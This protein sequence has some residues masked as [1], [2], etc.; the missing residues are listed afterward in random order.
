MKRDNKQQTLIETWDACQNSKYHIHL[1]FLPTS[2]P[3]PYLPLGDGLLQQFQ[4]Q[5]FGTL[6]LFRSAPA[7]HRL[8]IGISLAQVRKA[9]GI[10]LYRSGRRRV[11]MAIDLVQPWRMVGKVSKVVLMDLMDSL[12]DGFH[13]FHTNLEETNLFFDRKPCQSSQPPILFKTHPYH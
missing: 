13:S 8:L 2:T 4:P 9:K 6:R 11:L 5:S 1:Q 7:L 3:M 12:L 10:R